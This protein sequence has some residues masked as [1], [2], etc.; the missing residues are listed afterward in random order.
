MR[1]VTGPE[2]AKIFD[3]DL[4]T[5]G[6]YT[7]YNPKIDPSVDKSFATVLLSLKDRFGNLNA[8]QESEYELPSY[9]YWREACGM[10]LV[11]NWDEFDSLASAKVS[12]TFRKFYR[13]VEDIGLLSG[14]AAEK[15]VKGG[16]VGPTF[17]C[18]IAQHFSNLRNGDRFWYENGKYPSSFTPQQLEQIRRTTLAEVF[19][20]T[21]TTTK[22]IR[23]NVFDLDSSTCLNCDNPSLNVF[24]M[25]AWADG[26]NETSTD[27][28]KHKRSL[29]VEERKVK[30]RNK[31]TTTCR[32]PRTTR[33]AKK[34]TARRKT[35]TRRR[36]TK[37]PTTTTERPLKIKITNITTQT[38]NIHNSN[39]VPVHKIPSRPQ[40]SGYRPT[41]DTYDRPHDMTYLF[42]IVQ[43]TT[44]ISK[45]K[46]VEV[47]IKVQYFP[48]DQQN[49]S[50]ERPTFN[51]RPY[52]QYYAETDRFTARPT[53]TPY[54]H[55]DD[56]LSSSQNRPQYLHERPSYN[57]GLY[58]YKP[59]DNYDNLRPNRRPQASYDSDYTHV[60]SR[61]YRVYDRPKDSD[62]MYDPSDDIPTH[63]TFRQKLTK[64]RPI[65]K[66]RLPENFLYQGDRNFV[67]VS[68]IRGEVTDSPRK[69]EFSDSN[70]RENQKEIGKRRDDLEV[71]RTDIVP[72]AIG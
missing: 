29:D 18:I 53:K 54:N 12:Q 62:I 22:R 23:R 35:T 8:L 34:P 47:N 48:P 42:G 9:N 36:T 66:D 32:P 69:S 31:T 5:E 10:S 28:T 70:S 64:D 49:P 68:S 55:F 30:K 45:P 63:T 71:V 2:V 26:R 21:I 44:P 1:C 19:C 15:P 6:Y 38:Y 40:F 13:H 56:Y 27:K 57:D 17:A 20:K 59:T 4:Q 72:D 14:G 60:F 11:K 33:R 67:K 61:P 43:S 39:R 52:Q 25:T 24:D 7:K 16:I 41:Y 3:N 58:V 46:P 37:R 50:T 51:N 65:F